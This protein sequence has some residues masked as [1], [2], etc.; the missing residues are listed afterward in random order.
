MTLAVSRKLHPTVPHDWLC[1]G[2]LLVLN[3]PSCPDNNNLF[4]VRDVIILS[5][6][7]SKSVYKNFV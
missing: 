3:D 6:A 4:K 7:F 5:R 1:D 2:K